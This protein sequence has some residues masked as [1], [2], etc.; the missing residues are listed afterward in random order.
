LLALA[1][2]AIPEQPALPERRVEQDQPDLLALL[3]AP[4]EQDQQVQSDPQEGQGHRALLETLVLLDPQVLQGQQDP[5]VL[6]AQQEA[7]V[8]LALQAQLVLQ[9]RKVYFGR[10]H[11][12]AEQ[13]MLLM[14]Q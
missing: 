6:K 13:R 12:V 5:Q 3:E 11:G 14:M 10:T 2:R 1:I 4:E 9:G 8:Q 7:L